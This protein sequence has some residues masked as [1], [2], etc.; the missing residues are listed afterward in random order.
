MRLNGLQEELDRKVFRDNIRTTREI[1][2]Q[3]AFDRLRDPEVAPGP[4]G[5]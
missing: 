2:A 4:G 3:R 5:T 1:A